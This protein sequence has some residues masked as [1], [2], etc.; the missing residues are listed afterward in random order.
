MRGLIRRI[1][2]R[3]LG[4]VDKGCRREASRVF[5]SAGFGDQMGAAMAALWSY[6][7]SRVG[8]RLR[9]GSQGVAFGADRNNR[10]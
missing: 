7:A 10:T 2:A 9:A 8:D 5:A 6:E 4:A 3:V 1:C